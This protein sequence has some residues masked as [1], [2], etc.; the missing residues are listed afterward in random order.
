MGLT[1]AAL[2][3]Q[4][5]RTRLSAQKACQVAYPSN[6]ATGVKT[7][8]VG[9]MNIQQPAPSPLLHSDQGREAWLHRQYAG[10]GTGIAAAE[11]CHTT[12]HQQRNPPRGGARMSICGGCGHQA[13]PVPVS[14]CCT[15]CGSHYNSGQGSQVTHQILKD[16]VKGNRST[17]ACHGTDKPLGI[18]GSGSLVMREY[19]EAPPLPGMVAP[20]RTSTQ[21]RIVQPAPV[22][23]TI[24]APARKSYAYST[25]ELIK[26]TN[27]GYDANLAIRTCGTRTGACGSGDCACQ[28]SL[29]CSANVICGNWSDGVCPG[30]M[31]SRGQSCTTGNGTCGPNSGACAC[32][33]WTYKRSNSGYAANG[34]VDASLLTAHTARMTNTAALCKSQC[35][36]SPI[37]Q[38][39]IWPMFGYNAMRTSLSPYVGAQTNKIKPGWPSVD[40]S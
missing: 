35:T 33:S 3:H 2:V 23:K 17:L 25:S 13:G 10:A 5:N 36:A 31:T 26:K 24:T 8:R 21:V 28:C 37:I 9:K 16:T 32:Q 1:T 11:A 7:G 38:P 29:C 20:T 39:P 40:T 30:G 12:G 4:Q 19:T 27:I 34:A 15:E 18:Y 6:G 22:V 14:D